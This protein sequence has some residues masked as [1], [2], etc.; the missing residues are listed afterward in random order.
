M[1]EEEFRSRFDT[2]RRDS[3]LTWVAGGIA[4][5]IAVGIDSGKGIILLQGGGHISFADAEF[6]SA[7]WE[8]QP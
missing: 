4:K 6:I 7:P 8:G 1:T 2:D 5:G 3:R